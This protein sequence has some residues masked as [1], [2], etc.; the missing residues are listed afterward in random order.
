MQE[1]RIK[2]IFDLLS[3]SHT[4]IT[5]EK[6]AQLLSVGTKT[7]RNEI[8]ILDSIFAKNGGRIESKSGLGYH[9][10]VTDMVM[11]RTFIANKWHEF[12]F[13]DETLA[14]KSNRVIFLLKIMLFEKD[15][16][17]AIDLCDRLQF[18]NSQLS[19]DFQLL[20][21]KI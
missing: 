10:E 12:A 13:E 18:S 1:T 19:T 21:P 6:L 14:Y 8:K 2:K 17:K 11:F 20:R 9:F 15:Y 16:M 7:I 5:S 3:E 4:Y